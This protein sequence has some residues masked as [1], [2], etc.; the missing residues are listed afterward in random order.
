MAAPERARL[1]PLFSPRAVA[2]VGASANP[3]K[4][5]HTILKNII[6]GG[7]R[8]EVYPVNPR[9]GDILGKPAATSVAELPAGIDLAVVAIP[10]ALVPGIIRELGA[11]GVGA[12]V[13][14]SGG[15]REAGNEDLEEEL[16]A[17]IAEAGVRVVGP[18]CQGVVATG[19]R[20]CA[21]WPLTTEPG[22]IA[23]ISQ[24]GTVAAALAGWAEEERS[25][26]STV[27]SLGNC[28]DVD[29][30]DVLTYL[31]ND[32]STATAA[33]YTE[34][35]RDGRKF[36]A[37]ARAFRRA[38]KALFVLRPGRTDRG[39]K[40]AESHT[41]SMAGSYAVFLGVA[42]QVGA[43]IVPD[44]SVLF[45]AARTWAHFGG[46]SLPGLAV[47]TSSGGSGILAA[48]TAEERGYRLSDLAN[49]TAARLGEALPAHC[50]IG[51]PL[52]LTG[53]ADAGRFATAGRILLEAPETGTLL[54]IL[55]DPIPGAAAVMDELLAVSRKV[56][57]QVVACYMGGGQIEKAEVGSMRKRRML[58]FPTPE[59][60]AR[61][62]ALAYRAGP[63]EEEVDS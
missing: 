8:G 7:F 50:V 11:K 19:A 33:L 13:I 15:F 41:R 61:A 16:R 30:S 29:E 53:D 23:V 57:K 39:V 21:S 24:S 18:N 54:V 10:A 17:A 31:A 36:M 3:G 44:V 43:V 25:G 28:C 6:D 48:D 37:A 27:V 22:P 9:G 52:D 32:P 45:D 55:G 35:L 60:A 47:M 58:V 62:L 42:R 46:P 38:R 2:V 40:A 56:G 63:P 34:G 4:T 14:I 20:L 12:A 59:R 5:G 51:N 49:A 26:V 1:G